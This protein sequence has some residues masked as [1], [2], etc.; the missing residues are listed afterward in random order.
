MKN[1]MKIFGTMM[2]A[3]LL[4]ATGVSAA[5]QG[6][7]ATVSGRIIDT[8]GEG[9]A[10]AAVMVEGMAS[11]GTVSDVDG[12]YSLTFKIP[13][14]GKVT[15]EFSAISYLSSKVE[16]QASRTLDVELK[17]DYELLDE[18]VVV[19]YG[20]MRKSDITGS[21]TSV[22]VEETQAAQAT[23]LDQLLQGNAAGVQVV[24]NSAA[25]D[26]GINITVRGASSFNS[27][28]QP[29][30]VVDGVIM[31]TEGSMSLGSH[32]GS[33]AGVVED[34]NGLMGISP[35]DIASIEILK[36]ASAT[37]IYGSQGANGVVLITTKSS[38]QEKP[39]ITF[40]MGGSISHIYKKFD[41]MDATDYP[42]FLD[43]KGIE[44]TNS[45]YTAFTKDVENG[46][47]KPVDWQDY[48]TRVSFTQRYYLT[49]SGKPRNTNYRFSMG[50]YDNEGVMKGTGFEN[51]TL[52]LNLDKTVGRLNFGTKTAFSYL[53]S[54]MTQGA[55][56]TISQTPATS[57]VLSMLLTRPLMRVKAYDEDGFEIDDEGSPK[58]GPDRWLSDYQS[59]RTEFRIT[60]SVYA[61][62]KILPWLSF[63]ST[64]GSDYRSNERL[65][66]KTTRINTQATGSTGTVAHQDRFNW[67]WNNVFMVQKD[68][69]NHH[70]TGS[71]GE[72][73]SQNVVRTETV[74]GT[75][76]GQ[77]KAMAASLNTAPYTWLSYGEAKSRLMSFFGRGV[78]NFKHRYIFT[79][80]YRFDGSS[81]FMGANKWAQFPSF[82]FAWRFFKEPWFTVPNVSNAKLRVGWGR[83]GNQAIPSF[84]T[85]YRYSSSYTATHDNDSHKQV[86]IASYNIP[87]PNLKWETTTQYNTGLDL[88]FF[89]G[90]YTLTLDAYYKLTEDLLQTRIM[91]GSTG[92]TN[93]YV[94]MGSIAN[95]GIEITFN[96]TPIA[97]RNL[98][99]SIGGNFTL[100]RNKILSIDPTGAGRANIY[101][102]KDKPIQSVVYFTGRNLAGDAICNDY[103]NVFIEGYPMGLF[104][105]MPTDG[106]VQQGQMGVPL[107]DGKFRGA[108]A[109][110]FVDTNKDGVIT[111]ADRVVVGNPNPDFTYGFNTSLT[112]KRWTIT[113]Q[114]TGSYGNDIYNQQ[115]GV[116]TDVT[117][118]SANRLRAAVFDSWTP[119]NRDAKYPAIGAYTL[120]DVNWCTDRFVEDGSYLRLSNA[121]ITYAIPFWKFKNGRFPVKHMSIG[122]SGKNLYV[123]T[124]YSG[125]DPDVNVYG[126][127]LKYGVDNGAYPAARTWMFDLKLSF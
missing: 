43:L 93:P 99:W 55:G 49:I 46:I 94:N 89:K 124:K 126:N 82:A 2:A 34:N 9:I 19:G 66:F 107:S 61:Q 90:R 78:Y 110:N 85:R 6:K 33:D 29:L 92:V 111:A 108:G 96:A 30:Y 117:T 112:W 77:W 116:L 62:Y 69:G 102:Y 12:Y 123:W 64:L 79:A 98:E 97:K 60:P 63:R 120:N 72:S 44:P 41:L 37:A 103:I 84:Q 87:T 28:S 47:Y 3:V 65:V 39:A 104:Y 21:I 68:L 67:N 31:S 101:V 5:A 105:A 53:H 80:T 125:Y 15:L 36:D 48:A 7:S 81:K 58:S 95:K 54:R 27:N 50:Y 100:N 52:R 13:A 118:N 42:K 56:G 20:T 71:L 17:E 109:V 91:A 113:A 88:G 1:A 121:S 70:I 8:K 25:P 14:S 127:V 26:A 122:I 23:S 10:G 4:F 119:E 59:E 75:N 16:V 83:V 57:M 106:L 51:L 73:S 11:M 40:S 74:E 22:K 86:T 45:L 115:K 32:G 76:V 38:S 114:F 24:S 35:Q 18:A